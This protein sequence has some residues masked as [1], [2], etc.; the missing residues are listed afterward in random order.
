M[1]GAHCHSIVVDAGHVDAGKLADVAVGSVG[2]DDPLHMH[3]ELVVFSADACSGPFGHRCAGVG[4]ADE[5]V[6]APDIDSELARA[7]FECLDQVMLRD[8][9]GVDGASR[10]LAQVE[11]ER[12]EHEV[13]GVGLRRVVRASE[14]RKQAAMI[15][16]THHLTQEPVR[17][18]FTACLW[19][20][21]ND[22]GPDAGQ[23]ELARQ[24]QPRRAG[25][26]DENV[27]SMVRFPVRKKTY[28]PTVGTCSTQLGY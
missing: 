3:V 14:P 10:K 18:R 7:S 17:F 24:H 11:A 9:Q 28:T 4:E 12:P 1:R 16:H 20:P 6:A 2:T 25:P 13:R 22:D 23:R 26:Y 21:V 15:Q 19:K 27:E 8:R 5:S